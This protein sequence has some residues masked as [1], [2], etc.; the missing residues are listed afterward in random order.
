MQ[1][2]LLNISPTS[3]PAT[4]NQI[5]IHK[6]ANLRWGKKKN[7]PTRIER[8]RNCCCVS[9]MDGK[10]MVRR[11]NV[12]LFCFFF[13]CDERTMH[14]ANFSSTNKTYKLVCATIGRLFKIGV[15]DGDRNSFRLQF[16]V[17]IHGEQTACNC[18]IIKFVWFQID[19][20]L[21]NK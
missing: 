9:T 20:T 13:M 17:V 21:A 8:P 4:G 3:K 2:Q 7:W 6:K 16:V 10:M 11:L 14:Y 19:A 5:S 15:H 1:L 18:S 12:D